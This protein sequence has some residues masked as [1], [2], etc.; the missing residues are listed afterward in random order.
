MFVS[1]FEVGVQWCCS[2]D[3]ASWIHF[4]WLCKPHLRHCVRHED[5]QRR[6]QGKTGQ[7]HDR[8]KERGQAERN[9]RGGEDGKRRRATKDEMRQGFDR[10]VMSWEA[11]D[12]MR[13]W[14]QA[15]MREHHE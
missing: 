14:R 12:G 7:E 2:S 11:G 10:D 9:T 13:E 1:A 5:A 8:N 4:R 6:E 3:V 15:R